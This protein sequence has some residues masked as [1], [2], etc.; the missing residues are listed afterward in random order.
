MYNE[1]DLINQ[2]SSVTGYKVSFAE[3]TNMDWNQDTSTP[4]LTVGILQTS[5]ILADHNDIYANAYREIES[6]E[7]TVTTIQ[8]LCNRNELREVRE[9][10]KKSYTGYSPFP[11]DSNYSCMFFIKADML[12]KTSTKVFWQ[13]L[14]GLISPRISF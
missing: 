1:I 11:N 2:I 13:E 12:G 4:I 8:I 9:N 10:L 6:P 3:D 14:I 5:V 7:L